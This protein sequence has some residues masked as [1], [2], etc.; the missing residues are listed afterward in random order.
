[1][2]LRARKEGGYTIFELEGHLDFET[3]IQF[4]ET[5]ESLIGESLND[6]V[7]FNMEKLRFVGSSGINQ[8]IAV[9]KKLNAR[10]I[11]PRYCNLSSEFARMFKA[12]ETSRNPFYVFGTMSEAIESFSLPDKKPR[13]RKELSV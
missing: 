12:L 11:K 5:C 9:L 2:I 8:F 3:T 10:K 1:M 6:S 4:Q 7:I 13:T